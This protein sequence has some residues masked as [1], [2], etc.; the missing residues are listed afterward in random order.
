MAA[1][2]GKVAIVTGASRGIGEGIARF[3]AREGASVA[4]AARTAREGDHPKS[5]GSVETTLEAIRSEGGRA[6]GV[7]A[8]VSK[9]EEC[10]R[11][12]AETREAFGPVDVLVNNA[13]LTYF[14][15]I[16]DF[17]P[18]KWERTMAVNVNGPFNMSRAALA[19]MKPRGSGV[20]INIS[21]GS[22]RGPGRGPYDA[23]PSLKGG[24]LYGVTKAALERLTQ[25]LAEEVFA[26]GVS[27]VALSPSAVVPTPGT[28]FHM[29]V[30]DNNL[31]TE[32]PEMMER[33]ALLL[34]TTPPDKI[35]GRVCYSQ[36]IL[37][38]FGWIEQA[39]GA[40][41][42]RPGSPYSLI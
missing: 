6:I 42:D 33:A 2:D 14:S 4:C 35:S 11:I 28:A 19:D 9:A 30:F 22:S 32:A 23:P 1:L 3:F 5:P 10:E 18:D 37:R 21:S 12:V 16:A 38:E 26:D 31:E 8:D 34:A 17:R 29:D 7:L 13:A 39:R 27:V 36:E 40:N 15:E 24:V 41:V 25:G 20:I